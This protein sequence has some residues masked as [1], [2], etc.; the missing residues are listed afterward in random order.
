M[1]EW[2]GA[3]VTGGIFDY[4]PAH[5]TYSLPPEHAACLTDGPMNLAPMAAL[6]HAP[7]Q[8]RAPSRASVPRGRRRALR[9]VPARVH[10]RDGRHQP[11][12]VRRACSS[13]RTS[14]W[15]PGSSSGSRRASRVA[16]VACGTGPRARAAGARVPRRRPSSATTSTTER[17]RGRAPRRRARGS[18][19]CAS[20]S[21]TPRGS[22]VDEPFD[23][24]FVFD[25]VHDQVDPQA[26]LAR[27]HAA[28]AAGGVVRH[29]GAARR[30]HPRGQHRQPDGAD[31]LLACSTL[32]CMTV[33]LA[34]GG[35]GIGTMFGEQARPP[36]CS[37]T[38]ASSTSRCIPRPA[39]RLTRSTWLGG[40]PSL[41][42]SR[43]LAVGAIV[44]Q[45]ACL[46]GWVFAGVIERHGYSVT[47]DDISDLGALTAHHPA[48]VLVTCGVSGAVT[49]VFSL[50]ALRPELGLG[51]WLVALS[52]AGLDDLS[53]AFFRLD[54]RAADNGCSIATATASWHGKVHLAAAVVAAL[55]TVRRPLRARA[56]DARH[57]AMARP[58]APDPHLRCHRRAPCDRERRPHRHSCPGVGATHRRG[59]R[60]AR[61][62]GARREGAAAPVPAPSRDQE[63]AGV[64]PGG[65]EMSN[66]FN[67]NDTS[68]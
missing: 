10:R 4:D 16:D 57:R 5:R 37:P 29:E 18:P 51:A 15:S 63:N 67:V 58:R 28:L 62:R 61:R 1:R 64:L 44:A 13:T 7:R 27:I 32:H 30:R 31:P 46:A 39:T 53:D 33:S 60:P 41:M 43:R 59:D 11:R 54:C 19:T 40:E 6:Q 34:H 45:L 24:V 56:P 14:R 25:A 17:S 52:L 2:L 55:A 8:A 65:N 22:T 50:V 23:V 20:R 49:I 42:W 26:V 12:H 68:T 47:S 66:A 36:R 48:I 9:R 3:M 38:P 35:A 21:A